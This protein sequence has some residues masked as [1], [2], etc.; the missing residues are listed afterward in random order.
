[1]VRA[2]VCQNHPA[3]IA[4]NRCRACRGLFCVT[5]IQSKD[6]RGYCP[7]CRR[8]SDQPL[9][10]VDPA[11]TWYTKWSLVL[12]AAGVAY[13]I[14]VIILAQTAVLDRLNDPDLEFDVVFTLIDLGLL[15]I[16]GGFI[17]AVLAL[18]GASSDR[19]LAAYAAGWNLVNASVAFAG[20]ATNWFQF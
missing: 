14:G 1:M 15:L 10:P 20:L 4:P 11:Q 8:E 13:L 5:C 19:R 3:M 18:R 9:Q 2:D 6:R 16:L 17:L 12:G 7:S